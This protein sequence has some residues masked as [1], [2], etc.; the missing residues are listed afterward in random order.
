MD[1]DMLAVL[2]VILLL[3]QFLLAILAIIYPTNLLS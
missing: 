2:E 1:K 3:L